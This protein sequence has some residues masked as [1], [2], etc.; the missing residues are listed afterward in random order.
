MVI[1][2]LSIFCFPC[3]PCVNVKK[4]EGAHIQLLGLTVEP[5]AV[6]RLESLARVLCWE[7]LHI[8]TA[9]DRMRRTH[10]LVQFY[11]DYKTA[12]PFDRILNQS[13]RSI[14][15]WPFP[16]V[17]WLNVNKYTGLTQTIKS[18]FSRYS[19][20]LL[21]RTERKHE[22]MIL[23]AAGVHPLSETHSCH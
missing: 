10:S 12:F 5:W 16:W 21:S 7:A 18:N 11:G 8:D 15:V 14:L 9:L 23:V 13:I 6:Q 4:T 19:R 1:T 22:W 17:K 2:E 3:V 20:K